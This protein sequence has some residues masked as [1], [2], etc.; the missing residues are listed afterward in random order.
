MR[1][2]TMNK[3]K[4]ELKVT[5]LEVGVYADANY[6]SD[7]D[8]LLIG[9]GTLISDSLVSLLN[10]RNV[11]ELYKEITSEEKLQKIMSSEFEEL[12][13]IKP[14]KTISNLDSV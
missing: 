1:L 5:E 13:A 11:F 7:T 10:R 8:N 14:T 3:D 6:Y 4:K 9:K 12:D 2:F